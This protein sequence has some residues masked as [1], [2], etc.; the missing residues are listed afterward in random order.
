VESDYLT[1]LS[2]QTCAL[3]SKLLEAIYLNTELHQY[4]TGAMVEDE[5]DKRRLGPLGKIN[6]FVGAN[7][8]GKS[9]L[10]RL[11]AAT[12]RLKA[13][14]RLQFDSGEHFEVFAKDVRA[15]GAAIKDILAETRAEVNALA[16]TAEVLVSFRY[17]E[18]ADPKPN[19]ILA[20]IKAVAETSTP[21]SWSSGGN[22]DLAVLRSQRAARD[23][24]TSWIN[25]F[26]VER[27]VASLGTIDR[28]YIPTLRS[29]REIGT[30]EDIFEKQTR[31]AYFG[32]AKNIRIF[33]GLNLYDEVTSL[34]LGHHDERER[35]RDFEC[36]IGDS[37]FEG[38]PVSLVPKQSKNG[39]PREL[40]IK[41]G[42]E[43]EYPIRELGDGI[44][45]IIILTFP[46]FMQGDKPLL[47]F[48]EEPEL[49]MHPWLQRVFLEVLSKRFPSH[50]YFLTTHSNHFLDLTLDVDDVSVFTLEKMLQGDNQKQQE[51]Q[52]A[53]THVS[54]GDRRPL[55]LLGVRN[56]SVFLS[57]CTIWI[58]GITDRRYV[59][60][61]L[62]LYQQ[63]LT[64]SGEVEKAQWFKEDLH[65]SFVEYS[66]ANLVHW[67]LLDEDGPDVE[68][69]CGRLFLI[70]DS[71]GAT[72][73]SAKGQNHKRLAAKL[74]KD[75]WLL[76][77]KE[78]ENLTRPEVLLEVLKAYGEDAANLKLPA[79]TSYL[80]RPLGEFIE[81]KVLIDSAKK[82]R[83]ASYAKAKTIS[84]KSV[85]CGKV[86]AATSTWQEMSKEA[87]ELAA[88]V[89]E[90]ILTNNPRP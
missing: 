15:L 43:K 53:Y 87:Q 28:L 80:N 38:K 40:T 1:A 44:Q 18:E 36:F 19:E 33:T 78:I 82:K 25:R 31:A 45:S 42:T 20:K 26:D 89:F 70:A 37:F 85:F 47:A 81:Q 10:M 50:Q 73:A 83:A 68:R 57:N 4:S 23:I 62:E 48:I 30:T 76:P 75:F 14:P 34:L 60:H 8:S 11:L 66:G 49:F 59:A 24:T 72:E 13:V 9:R 6:L 71:D 51:A 64:Q 61:W 77:A 32:T 46:L 12:E 88:R 17:I 35:I 55:E 16:Q 52:F 54:G 65:Y 7:N 41:I 56:S 69:L 90:F 21:Q 79:H 3:M 58:E 67:S 27:L 39:S 63:H 84:D 74:G 29:L 2:Q 5:H 22:P 86:I